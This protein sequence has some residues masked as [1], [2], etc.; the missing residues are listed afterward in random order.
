VVFSG[1]YKARRF[2][3][4]I[5]VA[6]LLLTLLL[7][8]TG[9]V[10]RWD[11]DTIWAFVVGTNLIRSVPGIGPGLYRFLVAGEAIA[12]PALLR[13]YTWHVLGLAG[14]AAALITWHIFRVRRDGGI[15]RRMTT[16]RVKRAQLIRTEVT[17]M[18]LAL[19][20]L[21]AL[22]LAVDAPLGP[23]GDPTG[24]AAAPR[25][26]WFF[27]WVQELLRIG[28]PFVAGVMVPLLVLLIIV[29]L[30]YALDRS[31]AGMAVWFNRPGRLAQIVFVFVVVVLL[32]LTLRGA[33]R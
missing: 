25:A 17:A 27:L 30:P 32:I 15:S 13:F 29:A 26:P 5:G 8:F 18:L 6:L 20:G 4:L 2:N 24:L 19:A 16:P 33:T 7:D 14:V 28:M 9:Y 23:P 12:A 22:S 1:G 11:Q 31:D 10:L 3:W 21:L